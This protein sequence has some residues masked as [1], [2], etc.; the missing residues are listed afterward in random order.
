MSIR[1]AF[2][3]IF[4][5]RA[6][7]KKMGLS[8]LITLIPY[9]GSI[10]VL[11]YAQ[12]HLRD[13][14]WGREESLPEWS[15]FGGHLKTGFFALVV[16]FVYS[17]PLSIVLSLVIGV[18]VAFGT[19]RA[20]DS[21]SPEAFIILLVISIV[22]SFALSLAMTLVLWPTYTQVAL[23]D[24]MQAGFDFKG[25][26]ARAKA[27][28]AAYWRAARGSLLLGAAMMGFTFVLW[29]G[30]FAAFGYSLFTAP[31]DA[32]PVG[33]MMLL[34][35]EFVLIAIQLLIT[36]PMQIGTGHLWGAYAREAY[37]LAN[38]AVTEA[39]VQAAYEPEPTPEY[40]PPAPLG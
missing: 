18:T 2:R 39:T 9:V 34:P 30:W 16:G 27:N 26:Y 28:S 15:D 7:A 37:N 23:Y 29:G 8:A 33:V 10:A 19:I 17:L 14:A 1:E 11:G 6:W 36:V 32:P 21:G 35:A 22:L 13:V 12:R 20:I 40:L 5:D 24:T 31:S 4:S 25:I 38:P 3:A